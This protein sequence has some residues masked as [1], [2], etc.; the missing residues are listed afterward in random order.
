MSD[1]RAPSQDELDDLKVFEDQLRSLKPR[2]AA[3]EL[4]EVVERPF[5][6]KHP[7]ITPLRGRAW[8]AILI[9]T[10]SLG[11]AAGIAGT[12][13]YV[14]LATTSNQPEIVSTSSDRAIPI[15]ATT[16]SEEL[17]L[18]TT[19]VAQEERLSPW[20]L[21]ARG[22][23]RI[24][25]VR[26]T[27]TPRSFARELLAEDVPGFDNRELLFG[28]RRTDTSEKRNPGLP[29]AS[30]AILDSPPTK[31]DLPPPINQRLLLRNLLQT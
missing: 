5:V 2:H 9:A 22:V 30:N 31:L 15:D 14:R 20:S 6:L 27:L 28:I 26:E 7:Q 19:I 3:L 21:R 4:P 12:L 18:P 24:S 16:K 1:F 13:L 8:A 10:W 11:T 29:E 17:A 23:N 25:H